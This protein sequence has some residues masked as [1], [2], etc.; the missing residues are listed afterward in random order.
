MCI[1]I[2]YTV[3][4][5]YVAA[6]ERL[7]WF[8][9]K[10]SELMCSQKKSIMNICMLYLNT[11]THKPF[12]WSRKKEHMYPMY[13][14]TSQMLLFRFALEGSSMRSMWRTYLG[15]IESNYQHACTSVVVHSTTTEMDE[16]VCVFTRVVRIERGDRDSLSENR[17]T[18]TTCPCTEAKYKQPAVYMVQTPDHMNQQLCFLA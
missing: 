11:K 7:S 13:V 14:H 6:T 18:R 17:N 10:Y 1:G 12:A 5:I 16:C 4:I 3:V 2:L 8:P 9:C 15:L